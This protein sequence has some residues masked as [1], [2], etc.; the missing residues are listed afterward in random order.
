MAIGVLRGE[1]LAYVWL[2]AIRYP[3]EGCGKPVIGDAC[4]PRRYLTG[5]DPCTLSAAE[6]THIWHQGCAQRAGADL[7]SLDDNDD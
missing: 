2:L 7:D 1:P 4:I 5:E 3:C 6:A